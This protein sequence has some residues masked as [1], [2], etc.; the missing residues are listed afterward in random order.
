VAGASTSTSSS[1]SNELFHIYATLNGLDTIAQST[2]RIV[3]NH[4]P[5]LLD[6][7]SEEHDVLVRYGDANRA[8][9]RQQNIDQQPIINVYLSHY[10]SDVKNI[11]SPAAITKNVLKCGM[12]VTFLYDYRLLMRPLPL[13]ATA[14]ATRDEIDSDVFVSQSY[15]TTHTNMNVTSLRSRDSLTQQQQIMLAETQKRKKKSRKSPHKRMAMDDLEVLN[16]KPKRNS[17]PT[18]QLPAASASQEL[19]A[20]SSN[21][22]DTLNLLSELQTTPESA[23]AAEQRKNTVD[24]P[25]VKHSTV[26]SHN[27]K[28]PGSTPIAQPNP[29]DALKNANKSSRRRAKTIMQPQQQQPAIDPLKAA[30]VAAAHEYEKSSVT[31]SAVGSTAGCSREDSSRKSSSQ[32]K[33]TSSSQHPATASTSQDLVV[34]TT[35]LPTELGKSSEVAVEA[36]KQKSAE[37]KYSNKKNET[38]NT[39]DD[40]ERNVKGSSSPRPTNQ[41]LHATSKGIHV[42]AT[43]PTEAAPMNTKTKAPSLH[44]RDSLRPQKHTSPAATQKSKKKSR[45]S[46]SEHEA[47]KEAEVPKKK[48]K[49]SV[50]SSP[51]VHQSAVAV[52]TEKHKKE[53][54]PTSDSLKAVPIASS[55]TAALSIIDSNSSTNK[56]DKTFSPSN[57]ACMNNGTS[58]EGISM[59][60]LTMLT[61]I[62]LRDLCKIIKI[63]H[64]GSKK[65]LVDRLMKN[66]NSSE[67][68]ESTTSIAETSLVRT[69]V[70]TVDKKQHSERV[71]TN[72]AADAFKDAN[73]MSSGPKVN[74]LN[75]CSTTPQEASL[76]LNNLQQFMADKKRDSTKDINGEQLASQHTSPITTANDMVLSSRQMDTEDQP[77]KTT[78]TDSSNNI[79]SSGDCS[80]MDYLATLTSAQLKK[81]CSTIKIPHTGTK[82]A[83]IDRLVKNGLLFQG[84]GSKELMDQNADKKNVGPGNITASIME[85]SPMGTSE[86]AVK[87]QP[88]YVPVTSDAIANVSPLP[89]SM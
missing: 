51:I 88:S 5:W 67:G 58:G 56:E 61:K 6:E 80:N 55:A 71:T 68:C 81:M 27:N 49:T 84:H 22:T 45:K 48:P 50:G 33:I 21:P 64:S 12:I 69:I 16:K 11:I 46:S 44:S 36:K 63:P 74:N 2:Q 57:T 4:C 15:G 60:S 53:K 41:P 47:R 62:Q 13:A 17:K 32:R 28:V 85:A 19:T 3:E 40:K 34:T 79:I 7:L 89:A 66:R 29:P 75:V 39:P 37:D 65:N 70:N 35:K 10:N 82:K 26:T 43:T 54:Q 83:L 30:P 76:L 20:Q 59:D 24:E 1:D 38:I 86:N 72:T 31:A 14:A 8:Q 23:I 25:I 78:N 73:L 18:L 52:T 42:P 87:K 77:F 9:R